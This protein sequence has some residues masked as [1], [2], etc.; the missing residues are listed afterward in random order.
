MALIFDD[1][2]CKQNQNKNWKITLRATVNIPVFPFMWGF[3]HIN[4]C[5]ISSLFYSLQ[6]HLTYS[7]I[8]V[9]LLHIWNCHY[10]P[11]HRDYMTHI[12]QSIFYMLRWTLQASS[13]APHMPVSSLID[14]PNEL[15]WHKFIF[16]WLEVIFYKTKRGSG[17]LLIGSI[18]MWD[19][20][21]WFL[22]N[23][24]SKTFSQ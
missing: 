13:N 24:I 8:Y 19:S 15:Q 21:L 18:K 11:I 23:V 17:Y 9:S 20:L 2:N 22:R 7:C 16:V 10:D 6:S 1:E 14:V 12:H 3:V 4:L 5:V